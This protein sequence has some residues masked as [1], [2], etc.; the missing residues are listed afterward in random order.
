MPNTPNFRFCSWKK[1]PFQKEKRYDSF[2]RRFRRGQGSVW[3][4]FTTL[5][6]I[7]TSSTRTLATRLLVRPMGQACR[8]RSPDQGCSS[9]QE[10]CP[11]TMRPLEPMPGDRPCS[12]LKSI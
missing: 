2:V 6:P 5:S 11:K 9:Q 4:A 12:F 8:E 10:V 7:D 1:M 3:Q